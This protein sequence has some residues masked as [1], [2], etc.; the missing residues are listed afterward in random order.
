MR[1]T[2]F[3]VLSNLILNLGF[4]LCYLVAFAWAAIRMSAGSLTFGGMTAFLQ[5]VARSRLPAS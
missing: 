4:S 2:K 3:S 1:R 5:L